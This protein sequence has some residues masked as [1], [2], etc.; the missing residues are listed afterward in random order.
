M[1]ACAACNQ[2]KH[3]KPVANPLDSEQRLLDC[4]KE[5]EF[6]DHIVET[7]DG[8]W[9]WRT[10]AGKYHL[11]VIGLR[12]PCHQAK[13]LA[14]R[15]LAE[16]ILR[17]CTTAIQYLSLNPKDTQ[18]ELTKTVLDLVNHL[19]SFPPMVTDRG[20]ESVREWLRVQ[21]VDIGLFPAAESAKPGGA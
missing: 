4:T 2:T 16:R 1:L 13:R 21:G 7:A 14:R 8:Q 5:N 15:V 11:T 17:L 3:D 20:V 10:D 19:D 18:R 6:P 9:D 12:E